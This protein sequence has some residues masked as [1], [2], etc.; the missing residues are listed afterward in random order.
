MKLKNILTWPNSIDDSLKP[1]YHILW[2]LIFM[3]II[4]LGKVLVFIGILFSEGFSAAIDVWED[5]PYH[6]Y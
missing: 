1:W 5:M 4:M 6:I 2:S 3:P